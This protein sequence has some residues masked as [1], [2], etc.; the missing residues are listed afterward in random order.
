MY[1]YIRIQAYWRSWLLGNSATLLFPPP[2]HAS[3]SPIKLNTPLQ[4]C[5]R[6]ETETVWEWNSLVR[7][8]ELARITGTYVPLGS[9][10]YRQLPFPAAVRQLDEAK[11]LQLRSWRRRLTSKW[12]P[13]RFRAEPSSHWWLFAE[14]RPDGNIRCSAWTCSAAAMEGDGAHFMAVR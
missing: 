9:H 1:P 7:L 13:T 11:F 12:A 5:F 10:W 3:P 4:P 2:P 8:L 6:I 14:A